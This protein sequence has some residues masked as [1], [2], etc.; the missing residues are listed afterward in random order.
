M[1]HSVEREGLTDAAPT[2]TSYSWEKRRPSLAFSR[3]MWS[4][5]STTGMGGCSLI[6]GRGERESGESD[7][8]VPTP[9]TH[10]DTHNWLDHKASEAAGGTMRWLCIG[11]ERAHSVRQCMTRKEKEWRAGETERVA[12]DW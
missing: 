4:A 8:S 2:L 1:Q 7:L 12:E 6:P 10:T 5:R 3:S 11:E 9:D